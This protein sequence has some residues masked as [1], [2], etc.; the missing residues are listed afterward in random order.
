ME[1]RI[2]LVGVLAALLAG[3]LAPPAP[4]GAGDAS[5]IDTADVADGGA[6]I[7]RPPIDLL[8]D[9]NNCGAPG[10]QC[11]RALG[12]PLV[13]CEAGRCVCG[14]SRAACGSQFACSID[15]D[16]DNRHCGRCGGVCSP[17]AECVSGRCV[18][19]PEGYGT[20]GSPDGPRCRTRIDTVDNCGACGRVCGSAE[21]CMDQ[22]CQG[23]TVGLT[24]CFSRACVDLQTDRENCGMCGEACAVNETCT[25]GRCVE[26]P[27]PEDHENC[28]RCGVRCGV[29][30]TCALGRCVEVPCPEAGALRCNPASPICTSVLTDPMNCGAC[31]TLCLDGRTSTAVCAGGACVRT[32]RP[33]YVSCGAAPSCDTELA[34]SDEHCGRCDVRCGALSH[35]I[36]GVCT[37]LAARPV[38]PLSTVILGVQRP[39][40]RWERAE[41]VDGVRLQLC[42]DRACTR[43]ESTR[44]LTGDEH[45]PDVALTPGVHF[46]RL[47]ARRGASVAASSSPVWEFVV[48]AVDT[49]REITGLLHDIDG[50]GVEDVFSDL[51][52]QTMRHSAAPGE[53][54]AIPVTPSY[55]SSVDPWA[56]YTE[57]AYPEFSGDIDGDGFG[58]LVSSHI[59]RARVA[60]DTMQTRGCAL[61]RGGS[62]R[63]STSFRDVGMRDN[64]ATGYDSV[65]CSFVFDLDGDGHG[66]VVSSLQYSSSTTIKQVHFGGQSAWTTPAPD[67]LGSL[68]PSFYTSVAWGDFDG[69]ARMDLVHIGRENL[70]A[71]VQQI[72][73]IGFARGAG[74]PVVYGL[75]SCS[76]PPPFVALYPTAVMVLDANRDGFD[77]V[78]ANGSSG[79]ATY[80]GGPTGFARCVYEPA[81]P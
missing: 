42:A 66:D 29:S 22:T 70:G 64:R 33:G 55:R 73:V 4:G 65:G 46:W 26:V 39:R 31:G 9:P 67:V 43:V 20:C 54:Q 77:D 38:A 35:C 45:R 41:G 72:D 15:L 13:R 74:S 21:F 36:S 47:F 57:Q 48:P 50:D 80:L 68:A 19:C 7:D 69:D 27:C 1:W 44:D 3:C 79:V 75:P 56:V 71:F 32:C 53:A 11:S 76:P 5:P 51:L 12:R 16:V 34:F 59:H 60:S 52:H 28:G 23:C 8:S 61:L 6:V 58:D 17:D 10:V 18:P 14:G 2:G 40:F 62:P 49:G 37:S 81:V 78:R 63:F 30:E 24:R 25:L